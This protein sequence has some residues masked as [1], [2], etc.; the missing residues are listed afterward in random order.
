MFTPTFEKFREYARHYSVIPLVK[1]IHADLET[2]IRLY[3]RIKSEPYSVLLE[4][5]EGGLHWSR[6][7][8]IGMNPF[9]VVKGNGDVLTV[10]RNQQVETIHTNDPI[11]LLKQWLDEMRSPSIEGMP[12]FLGGVIG[13]IGYE[14]V[15]LIEPKKS[16]TKVMTDH[17][18]AH[19]FHLMWLDQVMVFDHLKQN[20]LFV[21]NICIPK[22]VTEEELAFLY[23]QGILDLEKWSNE[24]LQMPV[25]DEPTITW[26]QAPVDF[27]RVKPNISTE[28][29]KKLVETAKEYIR[30]GEI[31]QVVLSRSLTV[32]SAPDPFL[33]YRILRVLNP[34]PY[35][36][37][38]KLDD[39]IVVGT[40][41]ELLV[42]VIDRK[43]YIR[44]IAGS[45]PRGATPEEDAKLEQEL[46]TNEKERAEHVMLV[47]LAR[48]DLGRIAQFHSVKVTEQMVVE[49]YSHIM[50]LVSQVEAKLRDELHSLDAFFSSFP[51]GTLSGAPKV[52]AME[53]IAELEPDPRGVYGGAI[54]AFSFTGNI[55]SCIAI[56]T[57]YFKEGKAQVQAGAGIVYDSI[58]EMELKETIHK[59]MGMLKALQIA[60]VEV[61]KV[62]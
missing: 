20:L 60:S 29:F 28:H 5:V 52:R 46:M 31:Y 27:K 7:S 57:I 6:Y 1:T 43:A 55:D 50:H 13:Y 44:P 40:S 61:E 19:D 9:Q 3:S 15:R 47:D 12:A 45:R 62:C 2:P 51:A 33:V 38:L 25:P 10:I 21:K 39:E 22:E 41:P 49:K 34:S 18:K 58:P 35:M 30:N 8:F 42:K 37:I 14:M 56:R 23:E 36:Y 11:S 59:A 24:M 53:I 17:Q 26:N 54:G 4:S 32:E 16:V 48:N